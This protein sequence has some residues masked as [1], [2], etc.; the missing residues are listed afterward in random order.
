MTILYAGIDLAKN[1]FALHGV[2]AGGAVVLRQPRVGRAKLHEL[3]AGL[4]P[5]TIGVEACSGA[6]HWARLFA[7]HG[8]TVKLMAPKLVAPYR[9]SDKRGGNVA[10][11]A[12]RL[13]RSRRASAS[14]RPSEF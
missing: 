13:G 3:I 4:P 12:R 6:H 2:A 1:V 9:M 5:C 10:A 7:A 8:H 14:L 11:A